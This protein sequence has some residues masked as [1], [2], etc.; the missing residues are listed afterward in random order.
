MGSFVGVARPGR[1]PSR[2]AT[3]VWWKQPGYLTPNGYEEPPSMSDLAYEISMRETRLAML[4]ATFKKDLAEEHDL[5]GAKLEEK[6][7]AMTFT[8]DPANTTPMLQRWF[9]LVTLAEDPS[10]TT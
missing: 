3:N 9:K 8:K 5:S 1:S 6:L 7:A 2:V 4:E 10:A